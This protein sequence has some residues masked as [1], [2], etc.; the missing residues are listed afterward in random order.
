MTLHVDGVSDVTP[1][2]STPQVET[3]AMAGEGWATATPSGGALAQWLS[4]PARLRLACD[5]ASAGSC[6]VEHTTRLAG[7][8]YFDVAIRVR[9]DAGSGDQTRLILAAGRSSTDYVHGMLFANRQFETGRVQGGSYFGGFWNLADLSADLSGGDLA[10]GLTW[11]R[12][13]RSPLGVAWYY[14]R[15][16]TGDLPAVWS[17]IYSSVEREVAGQFGMAREGVKASNGRFVGIYNMTLSA[18]PN[19]ATV[20]A[21]E[22]GSPGAFGG[23]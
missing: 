4:G 5:P 8:D 19:T 15:S 13:H 14:G 9:L 23:A 16:V 21:V 7:G 10:D 11:F 2:P 1:T 22:W 6:G 12:I 18:V 20:L 3:D 17:L